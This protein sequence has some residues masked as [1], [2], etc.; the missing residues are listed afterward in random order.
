MPFP[1]VLP[2]DIASTVRRALSE[3]VGPG[4]VTAELLP[5]DQPA[6]AHVL[7]REAAVLCGTAW[8]DAVFRQLDP[9]IDLRWLARDGDEVAAD[10]VVCRLRGPAR[11]LLTGER[12]ALNFLQFL[13]GTATVTRHCVQ[14]LAG[15][16]AR[17]LDTRKTIPGLR[18][19]QKYAVACGGG[20]NHRMGLYDA[21]LIK[22]NHIRAAGGIAAALARAATCERPTQVEVRDLAELEAALDAG[23][24]H[25]LLDNFAV[26]TL[27]AAVRK[28]AGRARLEASG[29]VTPENLATIAATGVDDI[30]L[31]A[32]TKHVRAID[33]SLLVDG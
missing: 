24:R 18:T 23:A 14:Q 9:G 31:G 2:A 33:F 4:D 26:E 30:S 28:N 22:E 25:V 20:S 27:R 29:G 17:L 19:A 1:P 5:A 11:P 32:L 10:A 6:S 3:D 16:G 13:S 7:C 21:V 8:F 12:T 15:T